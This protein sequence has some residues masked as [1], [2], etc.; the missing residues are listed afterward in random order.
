MEQANFQKSK[1]QVTNRRRF[2]LGTR[3]GF[4]GRG[5]GRKRFSR[6]VTTPI[7]WNPRNPHRRQWMIRRRAMLNRRFGGR[8]HQVNHLSEI[9]SEF[10][11]DEV[12]LEC[13]EKEL[14]E[15]D[16]EA[17]AVYQMEV[18]E[19]EADYSELEEWAEEDEEDVPKN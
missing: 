15:V 2:P 4:R 3:G 13:L 10:T 9:D 18:A 12:A 16:P 1:V 7:P 17:F 11:A 19:Y 6:T 8:R 14:Q 5:R